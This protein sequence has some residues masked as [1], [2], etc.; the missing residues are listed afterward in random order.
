M[1]NS[2]TG[3]GRA[4]GQH[5]HIVLRVEVRSVNNR[6]LKVSTKSSDA[7]AFF[8]SQVEAIVKRHVTR[9]SVYVSLDCATA[10]DATEYEFNR[11]LLRSYLE[12]LKR[13]HVELGRDQ[14]VPI[15]ELINL[16]GVLQKATDAVGDEGAV[17]AQLAV[18][19]EEALVNMKEM[20]R[21]EGEHLKRDLEERCEQLSA[22]LAQ[23]EERAPEAIEAYRKRLT[24]RI[25]GM[26]KSVDVEADN[27]DFYREV[28]LFAERSDVAEEIS[29][30]KS[31][32]EQ[33]RE[34][35][36]SNEPVGR[37]IEFIAQEM[38]REANTMGSKANDTGMVRL[39]V[40]IKGEVDKMR[41]Q[42]ANVE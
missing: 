8:E 13:I 37:K 15:L 20:R 5:E 27:P 39:V 19:L 23:V 34:S 29:R 6:G 26:L 28:A 35:L 30:L 24:E 42:V 31:H 2:M 4:E 25:V 11:P 9:G 16:P 17:R 21:T 14:D 38:F 12:E 33:F 36:G 32:I 1:I 10:E 18:L 22:L 3:Y 7:V 40:D 41:E